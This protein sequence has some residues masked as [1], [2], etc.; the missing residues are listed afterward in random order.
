M[1]FQDSQLEETMT[2]GSSFGRVLSPTF[3]PKSQ[4]AAGGSTFKPTDISGCKLWF[5]FA[6]ANTLFTDAGSTKV[7]NDGDAIYQVN[8]KS[9][10]GFNATQSTA[11]NRPKYK[12]NIQN[13]KSAGYGDANDFMSHSYVLGTATDFTV[14]AVINYGSLANYRGITGTNWCAYTIH[15]DTSG[16]LYAGTTGLTRIMTST[17]FV[18]AGAD[19]IFALKKSGTSA[20][21]LSLYKNGGNPVTNS[22]AIAVN[23]VSATTAIFHYIAS[24]ESIGGSI[25]IYEIVVYGTALSDINRQSVETYLNDKW[26][27]Y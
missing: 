13:G 26:E 19:Y 6:D 4:A 2:F 3:H 11:D 23:P 18:S 1:D 7:A 10:N 5:D 27:I 22:G 15:T 17:G 20:G 16:R 25:Y 8:D 14:F 24:T 21:N 9:G 12:L